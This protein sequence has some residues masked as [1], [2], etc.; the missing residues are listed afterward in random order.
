MKNTWRQLFRRLAAA[1]MVSCSMAW[2]SAMCYARDA[3]DDASHSV[4][5]DGWQAGDNGGSGFTPWDFDA[6]VYYNGILYTPAFPGIRA[7]DDGAKSGTQFSNPHNTIGRAWV[8]AEEPESDVAV[9]AG[10]GFSPLQIGETFKIVIDNPT[11]QLGSKGYFVRLNGGTGGVNGN[12]CYGGVP[13][14]FE[15]GT[16]VT[17]MRFQMFHYGAG[18]GQWSV[19]DSGG[20]LTGVMDSDTSFAGAEFSVTR[21][22]EDTYDVLMDPFGPG[23]SFTQ[24]GRTFEN[25]GVPIDWVQLELF[26]DVPSDTTPTLDELQSDFYIRSM[27]IAGAA[28]PGIPGDYNGNGS[29]DAADYVVWRKNVGTN[30]TLPNNSLAGPIGTQHYNQWRQNFGR[31]G[32]G[33]LGAVAA[34]PEAGT[35]VYLVTAGVCAI[36]IHRKRSI[37]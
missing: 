18:Y 13:C 7:I 1:S 27:S 10:R 35:V 36:G 21:T 6:T 5:D 2:S 15:T 8:A 32:G 24:T 16:P 14:D 17:K 12:I 37:A 31:T 4:Y 11:E 22:G 25:P 19:V 26:V 30:N 28:P 34:V 33:G 23:P 9:Q 3:Y 20:D 29:V